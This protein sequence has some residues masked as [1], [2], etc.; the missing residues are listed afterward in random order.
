MTYSK[1]ELIDALCAE[2]EHLCHDDFDPDTDPTPEEY[3]AHLEYY[4]YD[5]LV[6]ET[7]TDEDFTLEEYM[8]TYGTLS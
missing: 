8:L 3:R 1:Q 4:E 6:E 5:E 2:Y 7:T